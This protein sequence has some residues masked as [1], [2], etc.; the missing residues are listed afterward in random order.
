MVDR[1]RSSGPKVLVVDDHLI[2]REFTTAALRDAGALVKPAGSAAAALE[3]ALSDPPDVIVMDVQLAGESG[4]EVIGRLQASWP[5]GMPFPRVFILSAEPISRDRLGVSGAAVEAVLQKP[6]SPRRLRELL[7]P[8]SAA[9]G[10]GSGESPWADSRLPELF[11]RELRVR[12]SEL[13]R[14]LYEG[15]PSEVEATL[16]QLI[17]SSGLCGES[18]LESGLRDMLAECRSGGTPAGLA[19]GYYSVWTAAASYLESG[20][21]LRTF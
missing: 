5:A 18:G 9:G 3:A 2:S 12:L 17:A 19:R 21:Q 10:V 13:D 15:R 1:S 20:G 11:R 14:H 8:G 16:H 6:V 4:L 7:I